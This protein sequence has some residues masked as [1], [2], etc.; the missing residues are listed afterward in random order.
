MLL[1]SHVST[2][3]NL[4]SSKAIH[5]LLMNRFDN[6]KTSVQGHYILRQM[7]HWLLLYMAWPWDLNIHEIVQPPID[8]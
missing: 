4:S 5:A 7:I 3:T 6:L 2:G 8:C 1:N